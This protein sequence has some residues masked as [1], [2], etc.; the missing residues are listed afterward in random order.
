MNIWSQFALVAGAHFLALLS[1]GPDFFLVLRSAMLHG[2]RKASGVCVGVALANAVF[3]AI[4][5]S[6]VAWLR[7]SG[8]LFTLLK[9]AGCVYL[10]W[11]G[12]RFLG[13]AG[14]LTWTATSVQE[15]ESSRWWR[16]FG[17]GFLSGIL[18]PKNSLFYASLFS[19]VIHPKTPIFVQRLYGLWMVITVLVWDLAIASAAG[20]PRV[21]AHFI[22][23][24]RSIE[25]VSGAALLTI[26]AAVIFSGR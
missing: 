6:G 23:R 18:N 19:L 11:L 8:P 20:H 10:A 7:D 16:E 2:V 9:W 25:R 5:L 13:H 3:I 22:A 24:V 12:W 26:A 15:Q 17:A 1:P 14:Q 4:A 21:I